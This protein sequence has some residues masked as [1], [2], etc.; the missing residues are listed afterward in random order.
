MESVIVFLGSGVSIPSGV[1]GV[2]EITRRVL[3][4]PY[5]RTTVENYYPGEAASLDIDWYSS[6]PFQLFL[7][8]LAAYARRYMN[9][10]QGVGDKPVE[11]TYEDLYYLCDQIRDDIRGTGI[12]PAVH[13]FARL[14]AEETGE[15]TGS[16]PNE[17]KQGLPSFVYESRL[18]ISSVVW[19]ALDGV[20]DPV[21]LDL[22]V[23]I[24]SSRRVSE[25]SVVTLNHDTLVERLFRS[26]GVA[27]EDG[28]G[29][30]GGSVRW[31]E[32][33]RLF[34]DGV[35][36]RL[37]KPHGSVDWYWYRPNPQDPSDQLP[38]RYGIHAGDDIHHSTDAEGR[39]L[40]DLNTVPLFL[41]G[42]GKELLYNS[43]IYGGMYDAFLHA[44]RRTDTVVMSGY[45]WND[46]AVSSRLYT[47]LD[48]DPNRRLVI[49]H[50]TPS[51]LWTDARSGGALPAY[52]E[53]G[54]VISIPKWLQ[55]ADWGEVLSALDA[56]R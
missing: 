39:D 34:R 41:S 3:N 29:D 9:R 11:P 19:H 27:F 33:D 20:A 28:F 6:R 25:V 26:K 36:V 14:V 42:T 53:R 38:D 10:R 12:N 43:G 2:E 16:H 18:L 45:G 4:D 23:D 49:L 7:E 30:V 50:E 15:I 44:L 35:R 17:Y 1:P 24:T 56:S 32:P 46:T 48:G 52:I 47:W 40:I 5:Y 22:V 8:Y 21:G 37:I 54:Q 55:D 51:R 13:E 31:Y